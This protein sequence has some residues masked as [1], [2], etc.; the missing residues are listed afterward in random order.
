MPALKQ[1]SHCVSLPASIALL[2]PGLLSGAG[3]ESGAKAHGYR[4]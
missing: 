1:S 2:F 4:P 3:A